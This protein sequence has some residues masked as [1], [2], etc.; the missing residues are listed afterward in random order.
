M[1]K[2]VDADGNITFS[3]HPP[4]TEKL[5]EQNLDVE[6]LQVKDA[7]AATRLEKKGQDM[8][9]GDIRLPDRSYKKTAH[10]YV[11]LVNRRLSDWRESLQDREARAAAVNRRV[12]ERMQ[13]RYYRDSTHY[14]SSV[15]GRYQKQQDR[16]KQRMRDLRCA[17]QWAET[18]TTDNRDAIEAGQAE[19]TRLEGI[20]SKLEDT[21]YQRCGELPEYD[22]TEKRQSA[23]R[24]RWYDCSKKYRKELKTVNRK[25]N[26]L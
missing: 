22:P 17:I 9:C 23:A 3:Q 16:D 26:Q 7:S 6:G 20:K 4:S 19:L 11:S 15:N 14:Q 8:Y 10:A 18:Y 1:Y 25:I 5:T 12:N 2:I 24:K 21:L 13:S